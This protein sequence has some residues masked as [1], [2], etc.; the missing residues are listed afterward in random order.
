MAQ[1]KLTVTPIDGD[2]VTVGVGPKVIVECERHF[3]QP[4]SKLFSGDTLSYE[5]LAWAAW[6]S[7]M[8]K[9]MDVKTFDL[10]LDGVE[11]ITAA[12]DDQL[13]LSAA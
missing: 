4:F 3:K 11:D 2:P 12:E 5:S 8:V 10:W 9:G 7:M 1:M 13:P 6:K